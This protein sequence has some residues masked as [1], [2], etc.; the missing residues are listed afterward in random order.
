MHLQLSS[1]AAVTFGAMLCLAQANAVNAPTTLSTV[2]RRR[3][4]HQEGQRTYGAPTGSERASSSARASILPLPSLPIPV[5]PYPDVARDQNIAPVPIFSIPATSTPPAWIP[6]VIP[7]QDKKN[8]NI[9]PVPIV[10][11]MPSIVTSVRSS[12]AAPAGTGA[13]SISPHIPG[14]LSPS[15][16]PS[17]SDAAPSAPFPTG[18]RSS[19]VAYLNEDGRPAD[20]GAYVRN[21]PYPPG[22]SAYLENQEDDEGDDEDLNDGWDGTGFLDRVGKFT[23]IMRFKYG[24]RNVDMDQDGI[25]H[26]GKK[27]YREGRGDSSADVGSFAQLGGGDPNEAHRETV[28]CRRRMEASGWR[29]DVA[30]NEEDGFWVI[31]VFKEIGTYKRRQVSHARGEFA[32]LLSSPSLKLE[33]NNLA[34][35]TVTYSHRVKFKPGVQYQFS[36]GHYHLAQVTGTLSLKFMY[37]GGSISLPA[38]LGN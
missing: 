34:S 31:P 17:A 36:F 16:R 14:S 38:Q 29:M 12:R 7:Y 18:Q 5:I 3:S 25:A 32:I 33:F 28:G 4:P 26:R 23:D 13:A 27:S 37:P 20:G 35:D 19:V 1:A 30:L 9:A 24:G 11:A 22:N 2:H 10:S 21:S 8:P 15:V 6:H